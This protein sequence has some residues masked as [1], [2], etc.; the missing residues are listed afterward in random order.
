[1]TLQYLTVMRRIQMIKDLGATLEALKP[2]L[3]KYLQTQGTKFSGKLFTCPHKDLHKNQ[4]MKP[5]CNF[6]DAT[7]SRYFCYCCGSKGD[8]IDAVHALE[9]R[10]IT[11]VGF[12]ET[13]EYLCKLL[14]I[15]YTLAEESPASIFVKEVEDFI[16]AIVKQGHK[17]LI[18]LIKTQ[19]EHP[20]VKLLNEKG[21]TGSVE[22]YR[23]GVIFSAKKPTGKLLDVCNFLNLDVDSLPNAIV[24][25]IEHQHRLVGFQLRQTPLNDLHG[26]KYQTFLST[27]K[28]L[29]NLDNINSQNPVYIVEGASSVIV[30]NN[31]GITNVVA[32]LGNKLSQGQYES[33]IGR[34]VKEISVVYDN[35]AG[36]EDGRKNVCKTL[37]PKQ[38]MTVTFRLLVQEN[39]PADYALKGGDITKLTPISLWDYLVKLGE[40]ELLFK[41][42]AIQKDLIIK[43]HRISELAKT[44]NTT[45][46]IIMDEV[47]KL[48]SPTEEAPT[49]MIIREREALVESIN[50]FE[51]WAWSRG[52]LLGVKSFS[53]FDKNLDGLQNGLL[54]LS[55]PPNVGKSALM[56]SLCEKVIDMNPNAYIIY[57]TIDDSAIVTTA[58]FLASLSGIPINIVSNPKHRIIN[59]PYLSDTEKKELIVKRE[60]SL[61]YLRTHVAMFNLKDAEHGYTIEYVLTLFKS[62][63]PLMKDKQPIFFLDNL[64][65]L[66]SVKDFK[67]DKAMVDMIGG[68]L[69]LLSSIYHCPVISTAEHTKSAIQ[70]GEVGGSALK[71]TSSLH[72]EASLIMSLV[73]KQELGN[74]KLMDVT[75]TKNKISSFIGALPFKFY[76]ELSKMEESVLA[77]D[78]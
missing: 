8:I 29:F 75:I 55:G 14:K 41:N 15:P 48:E 28:A 13:V 23:L 62:L 56:V 77:E 24:I 4:D 38:E 2:Q 43:E 16:G 36:G 66:R 25:P 70:M 49:V 54:L 58:R 60:T 27:P 7:E 44:L 69:K 19:P 18:E 72:Y 22:K 67:S 42:T 21:W 1:M 5:A 59:N 46:S 40:Q 64:H 9:G 39:D 74:F 71:E 53:S 11:G 52:E 17:N 65:K 6:L 63:K 61:D 35:D 50:S 3:K 37:A 30:L 12:H 51:K 45:K 10:P 76:P 47:Q 57:L 32:T 26:R 31:L 34:D 68:N 33:L 20:I 73:M 78:K